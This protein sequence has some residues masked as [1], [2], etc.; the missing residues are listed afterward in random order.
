M[1]EEE[2]GEG[3]GRV[4]KEEEREEK[5]TYRSRDEEFERFDDEGKPNRGGIK[6]RRR[7]KRGIGKVDRMNE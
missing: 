1:E 6:G 2:K 4:N 3:K 5:G 7:D